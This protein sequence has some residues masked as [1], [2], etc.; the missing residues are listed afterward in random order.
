MKTI[1]VDVFDLNKQVQ[2]LRKLG[3]KFEE[4]NLAGFTSVNGIV[5]YG[6]ERMAFLKDSEGN[7][8]IY[9]Q[10]KIH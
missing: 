10:A 7:L 1:Q 3:I 2:S 5:D 9:T 4:Y 8:I 6:S